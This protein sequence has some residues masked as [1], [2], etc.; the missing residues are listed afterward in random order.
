M[1]G[2]PI[3]A[4]LIDLI[5][6][7]RADELALISTLTDAEREM[8][9]TLDHWSAK[10]HVAHLTLWRKILVERLSAA[11]RSE[12][13]EKHDNYLEINDRGFEADRYLTWEKVLAESYRSYDELLAKMAEMSEEELTDPGRYPWLAGEPLTRN[14]HGDG[15]DHTQIHLSQLY[16]ERGDRER[17]FKIQRDLLDTILRTEPSPRARGT[18]I[19]NLGCFLALNGEPAE[20]IERVK[21]SFALR[22]D[23]QE[24]SK[25]DTDLN[26]LREL[27]EFQEVYRASSPP[28]PSPPSEGRG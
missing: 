26:S 16:L 21:E 1:A 11:Q 15:C 17:A 10:D 2:E 20:A 3:K 6:R 25:Q 28:A 9:G 27:P 12:T 14:V 24:W 23:L 7:A 22:P 4:Q 19:Y 8:Q 13:P 5:R 18:A